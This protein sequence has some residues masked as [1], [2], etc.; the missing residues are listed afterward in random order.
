MTFR[1]K[2]V[3]HLVIL[4][5][6][7][8]II[9]VLLSSNFTHVKTVYNNFTFSGVQI[10]VDNVDTNGTTT[11]SKGIHHHIGHEGHN[12]FELAASAHNVCVA[13]KIS[14]SGA[15]KTIHAIPGKR[16]LY[17]PMEK[18]GTTFWRRV[19]HMLVASDRAKY[20]QPYDVPIHIALGQAKRFT[21]TI[22]SAK[23]GN[24]LTQS[25]FSF[26]FVRNPYSRLLSAFID[27]LVPPN[28]TFWK[29]FG[30]RAIAQYRPKDA[31]VPNA[32]KSSTHGGHDV[33]FAEFVKFV[34]NAEKTGKGIDPHIV[35]IN[36]G[37][38][39]CTYN[40]KFIGRMESFK[41]D[42]FFIMQKL[43]MNRTITIMETSFSDYT[44]D[45]AITD[46]IRSPFQWKKEIVK[47]ISWEKALHRIWLK[48]QMRGIVQTNINLNIAKGHFD[49]VNVN[50]FIEMAR[51]AHR[52][53]DPVE[54]K[55]Q[56]DMVKKEAF[57]TVPLSDIKAFSQAFK[58]DFDLFGYD[59][60]PA[61]IF[62]RSS[63]EPQEPTRFFNYTHLN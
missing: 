57:A 11:T 42:A 40:Y 60:M 17:C 45:D 21:Q 7:L 27:K 18:I 44:L 1:Q 33:T 20:K 29:G 52:E 48:L 61:Y 39:P 28:P 51:K 3:K 30:L 35:S 6:L 16:L 46:S 25:A 55:K 34:V 8:I 49:S 41:D 12:G 22:S 63:S 62:N 23:S 36:K 47:Y 59:P 15:M 10:V 14:S 24:L 31:K 38:K 32:G 5:V 58:P 4:G 19:F 56:K 53:S 37:C 26:L 54:L 9:Q 43:D 2:C 50:Q 13:N